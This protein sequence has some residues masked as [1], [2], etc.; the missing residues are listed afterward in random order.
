MYLDHLWLVWGWFVGTHHLTSEWDEF[1][2]FLPTPSHK[3]TCCFFPTYV[4][5]KANN[6]HNAVFNKLCVFCGEKM[7]LQIKVTGRPANEKQGM[8]RSRIQWEFI[9]NSS[10]E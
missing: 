10:F 4:H 3:S 1:T 6:P 8:Y 9:D 7:A 5:C 2:S